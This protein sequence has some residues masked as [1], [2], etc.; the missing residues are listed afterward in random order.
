MFL[1][2]NDLPVPPDRTPD[3][4]VEEPPDAPQNEPDAPVREPGPTPP[5]RL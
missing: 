2:D 5:K 1:R 3:A 4:P